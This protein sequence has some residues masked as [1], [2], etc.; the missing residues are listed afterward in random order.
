VYEAVTE[1]LDERVAVVFLVPDD[2]TWRRR[3]VAGYQSFAR[4]IHRGSARVLDVSRDT[5]RRPY[6][7]VEWL[8]ESLAQR[9]AAGGP[10]PVTEVSA[11]LHVLLDALRD[12]HRD[13]PPLVH[14]GIGPQRIG[15]R[16]D[17]TA[18]LVGFEHALRVG[19]DLRPGYPSGYA[20]PELVREPASPATDV[21]ALGVVALFAASGVG[22]ERPAA[23]RE[24]ALQGLPEG[25]RE[26]LAPM[27]APDPGRRAPSAS[28]ALA[29]LA[30]VEEGVRRQARAAAASGHPT[31]AAARPAPEPIPG[32]EPFVRP[33]KAAPEWPT[34]AVPAAPIPSPP[35]PARSKVGVLMWILFGLLASCGVCTF[36][37]VLGNEDAEESV[38]RGPVPAPRREPLA[39]PPSEVPAPAEPPASP[40]FEPVAVE[41]RVTST[42][43]RPPVPRGETCT[44][45]VEPA[46]SPS[47]TC[48][49]F[50]DCGSERIYGAGEAGYN[51]CT[52]VDGAPETASDG[53]DDDGD[54]KLALDL[55]GRRVVVSTG[56]ENEGWVVVVELPRAAD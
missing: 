38:P 43:G 29:D 37:L 47:F 5:A 40:A 54:P 34:P 7:V 22:P 9:V 39:A 11:I 26:V 41:G 42:L 3:F 45:R 51:A 27:L 20:A 30:A 4:S 48:R 17:G 50:V 1:P 6:A 10:L 15:F 2:P 32:D 12:F 25:L 24:A 28:A 49:V 35:A 8:G 44:V 14:G 36:A 31:L 33:W 23:E 53:A 19:D 52:I 18:A 16:S 13:R 56:G 21:F 46:Q 55:P